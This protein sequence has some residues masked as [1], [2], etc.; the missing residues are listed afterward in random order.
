MTLC[1]FQRS[2]GVE[3]GRHYYKLCVHIV[4]LNVIV[5]VWEGLKGSYPKNVFWE[6]KAGQRL[7]LS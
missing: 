1:M 4:G 6:V 3:K 2:I 7:L 5:C